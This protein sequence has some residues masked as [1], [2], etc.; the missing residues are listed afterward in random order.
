MYVYMYLYTHI[1]MHTYIYKHGI[2]RNI[3]VMDINF[4]IPWSYIQALDA[5]S[6][7]S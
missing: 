5:L 2:I 4:K 7:H 1:E 6:G 3:G